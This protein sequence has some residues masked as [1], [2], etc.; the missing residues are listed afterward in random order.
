MK[1]NYFAFFVVLFTTILATSALHAGN[2]GSDNSPEFVLRTSV[3]EVVLHIGVIDSHSK[4]VPELTASDVSLYENG[5]PAPAFRSF[6]REDNLPLK[7]GILIDGSGSVEHLWRDETK[8]ANAFLARI[9]RTGDV[10]FVARFTQKVTVVQD[11]TGDVKKM[12]QALGHVDIDGETAMY[13]AVFWAEHKLTSERNG[14]ST[15]TVLLLV[16]DVDDNRS[17]ATF[18]QTKQMLS[19]SEVLLYSVGMGFNVCSGTSSSC[20]EDT[21]SMDILKNLSKATGGT[22]F[23]PHEPG[24]FAK[25]GNQITEDLR[26]YYRVSYSPT[27]PTDKAYRHLSAKVVLQGHKMAVHMRSG[28]KTAE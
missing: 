14:Q 26:T 4:T 28:Y 1:R 11:W 16:T 2:S 8:A 3:N 5:K 22:A 21:W 18:E 9:M 19:H 25:V 7:I 10:G 27:N 24:Q 13:D 20:A 17:T 12:Q 6:V 15:R 23:F